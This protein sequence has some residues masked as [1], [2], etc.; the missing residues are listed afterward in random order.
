MATTAW[1]HRDEVPSRSSDCIMPPLRTIFFRVEGMR[2]DRPLSPRRT[3]G[4][5]GD[6]RCRRKRLS[7]TAEPNADKRKPAIDPLADGHHVLT[8]G[9]PI[10]DVKRSIG[11]DIAE[12]H[13]A[14]TD[15]GDGIAVVLKAVIARGTP[16]A[17]CFV[18]ACGLDGSRGSN[19]GQ[20]SENAALILATGLFGL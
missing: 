19:E 14:R 18:D 1:V 5:C 10:A 11:V 3:W 4:R 15:H 6:V 20:T 16:P 8:A 17:R 12:L 2:I 9:E 13:A 7:A